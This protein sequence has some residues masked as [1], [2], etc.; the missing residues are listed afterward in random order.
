MNTVYAFIIIDL[1]C[2]R[3]LETV[4]HS[5]K[6]LIH[7][8]IMYCLVYYESKLFIVYMNIVYAFIIIDVICVRCMETEKL[9]CKYI[10]YRSIMYCLI[11]NET[12]ICTLSMHL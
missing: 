8:S 12:K 4:K 5:G 2:V 10:I 6:Y 3:C 1:I 9:Y 7:R 11:Y